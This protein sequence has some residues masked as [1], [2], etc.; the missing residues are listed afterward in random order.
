[1][2]LIKISLISNF[3]NENICEDKKIND[4]IQIVQQIINNEEKFEQD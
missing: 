3:I 2:H 4:L 1:M